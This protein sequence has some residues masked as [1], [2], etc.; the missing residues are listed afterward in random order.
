M[1]NNLEKN[2]IS[3]YKWINIK[4]HAKVVVLG[5]FLP[6]QKVTEHKFQQVQNNNL[7]KIKTIRS[8]KA[9]KSEP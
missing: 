9:V 7:E 5:L 8:K 2:K 3:N 4:Y 1:K 6:K